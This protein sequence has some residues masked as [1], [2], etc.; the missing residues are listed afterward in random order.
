[1]GSEHVRMAQPPSTLP[2]G[3]RL[4]SYQTEMLE[5]SLQ[6]NVI[7]AMD[8]GSGKT[9]IAIARIRVELERNDKLV[10]F[11]TPSKTLA[12]QQY[13][14]LSAELSGYGIRLLTGAD[15]CEKWSDQRLWDASLTNIRVVV[16]TPAI[17]LDALTHAFMHMTRLALCV[18][19]EAHHCTKKHPMS[20]IMK[21]FYH[22]ARERGESVPHILGLSASP[23][24]SSKEGMLQAIESNL[25]AI[26]ITPKQHRRELETFV[27]PPEVQNIVYTALSDAPPGRLT[28]ALTYL[29]QT[30]D[31]STDPYVLELTERDDEKSRKELEKTIMKRK[32]Y[33]LDQLRALDIRAGFLLE[34]IG[35]SMADWYVAACIRQFRSGL[36]LDYVVLP[37][38]SEKER[39]HLARIFDHILELA[40][41]TP[42]TNRSDVT[43]KA[44]EL[45]RILV[46]HANPSLRGIVFVEQ[47]VLV[48]V[49]AEWLRGLPE[50][51]DY[52]RI[53]AFV[54][55]STSTNRKISVADLVALQDQTRDLEAFRCGEKN[56]MIATNVL[57]E[58]IDISACNVV[59]CFDPPKNLVSF[60]Q[61][62]GRARQQ[63]S[64]YF[65]FTKAN[66]IG[67][68][69]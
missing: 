67:K 47:R 45:F 18:F 6:K 25:N 31:L 34:Q 4:R 30:Y 58:G 51:K 28:A 16:A 24:V 27:H 22:P 17:L 32:T 41:A 50:L 53:A 55:T 9:H 21:L 54:G 63:Q 10:W 38:L 5:T 44:T 8:T 29:V 43:A 15:G 19:D 35:A 37:D 42:D 66:G 1:M 60:V 3:I 56:L 20:S 64:S 49:L 13:Q 39:Q 11:L 62:R 57:E 23:V 40:P 26:T 14:V 65:I 59:I 2:Q 52:Y 33:C 46:K 69:R 36:M 68:Q 7:V 61:R 48:T 12:E